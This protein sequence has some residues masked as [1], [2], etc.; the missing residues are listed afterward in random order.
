MHSHLTRRDILATLAS[1]SV[2]AS[3][4]AAQPT[5]QPTAQPAA[6]PARPRDP[7]T[8]CLNTSTIRGQALSITDEIDIASRAGYQAIEPWINELERYVQG[9][10]NLRDL[11]R[12]IRDAGLVVPSAI[13]FMDWVVDDETRRRRGLEVARQAMDM[14]QQIGGRRLA[15]P[16][17]GATNQTDLSTMRAAE[18]YRALLEVGARIGVVPQCE[19]WGFSKSLSRLGECVMIA[20]ESGHPQACVLADVYHL[21]KGGSG[22]GGLHLLGSDALQVF[23]MN[24]YPAEPGRDA[25]TDAHRVYPGDGVAPLTQMLRDLRRIGFQGTLSLELFNPEYWRQDALTVART[26]LDKMRTVVRGSLEG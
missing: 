22:F 13:G 10:G 19:V 21:H 5:A 4:A 1:S 24:D 12:R 17:V 18:R 16:P 20:V 15:A 2:A 23:H 6:E 7:F 8:Y 9:G 3:T 26:G 11:G 25:I 14:V